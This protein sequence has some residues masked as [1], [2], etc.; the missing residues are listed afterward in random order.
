MQTD[1][2]LL[3]FAFTHSDLSHIQSYGSGGIQLNESKAAFKFS[4]VKLIDILLLGDTV[5]LNLKTEN[6][7]QSAW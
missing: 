6:A 7:R 4:N 1:L 3:K 5:M 2:N